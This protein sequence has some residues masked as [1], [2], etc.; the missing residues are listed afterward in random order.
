[1]NNRM[2]LVLGIFI[3]LITSFIVTL[4]KVVHHIV[5]ATFSAVILSFGKD[6]K[7]LLGFDKEIIAYIVINK[8]SSYITNL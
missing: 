1:M 7:V 4:K 6:L 2:L 8:P 5:G 3:T